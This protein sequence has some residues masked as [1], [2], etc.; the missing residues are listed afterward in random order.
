MWNKF[1]LTYFEN[2]LTLELSGELLFRHYASK[3]ELIYVDDSKNK[4][5]RQRL[6]NHVFSFKGFFIYSTEV[7]FF[8]NQTFKTLLCKA[9]IKTCNNWVFLLVFRL[10]YLIFS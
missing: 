2:F 4:E 6:A 7:W 5:N 3:N 8:N 1:G 10:D 9:G